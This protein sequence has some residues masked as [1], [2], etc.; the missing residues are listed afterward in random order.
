[1]DPDVALGARSAARAS[2]REGDDRRRDED[3]QSPSSNHM[4]SPC[5]ADGGDE[6]ATRRLHTRR[7]LPNFRSRGESAPATSAAT[8][9]WPKPLL[10]SEL[11]TRSSPEV[12]SALVPSV[13]IDSIAISIWQRAGVIQR[14]DP[15]PG[16]ARRFRQRLVHRE[17][18]AS[19]VAAGVEAEDSG[20]AVEIVR[21]RQLRDDI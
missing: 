14:A 1:G 18:P 16:T 2:A 21:G 9:G 19:R 4:A 12:K 10:R 5:D 7:P 6:I 15:L 20:H 13:E 11:L 17:H 8:R 3:C